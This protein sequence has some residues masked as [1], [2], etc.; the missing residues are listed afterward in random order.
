[1]HT[2]ATGTNS[3]LLDMLILIV[4]GLRTLDSNT[5]GIFGLQEFVGWQELNTQK[6]WSFDPS[7]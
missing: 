6:R 1:M 2:T 5:I 4:A 3:F 7:K